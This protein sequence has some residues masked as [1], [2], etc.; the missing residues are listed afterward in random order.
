M[1]KMHGSS[2]SRY[3]DT[4]FVNF[5]KTRVAALFAAGLIVEGLRAGIAGKPISR[6][7]FPGKKLSA[8]AARPS[9]STDLAGYPL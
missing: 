8:V 9:S 4:T 6:L 1:I 2:S 3:A 5:V 7:T